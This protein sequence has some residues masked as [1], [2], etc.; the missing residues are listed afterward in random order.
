MD[1]DSDKG[2][3]P[4]REEYTGIRLG[5]Q[6][7]LNSSQDA[8]LL[9]STS[10]MKTTDDDD[11]GLVTILPD[12]GTATVIRKKRHNQKKLAYMASGHKLSAKFRRLSSSKSL[13]FQKQIRSR[14]CSG[15][16]SG[17]AEQF[18]APVEPSPGLNLGD[19]PIIDSTPM[20]STE[21]PSVK[22][23][24]L[25]NRSTTSRELDIAMAGL[26]EDVV[27]V[28]GRAPVAQKLDVS[29]EAQHVPGQHAIAQA[30]PAKLEALEMNRVDLA[31]SP[32]LVSTLAPL[33]P[34]A[35][36]FAVAF[37]KQPL[38]R[39]NR[40]LSPTTTSNGHAKSQRASAL[41]EIQTNKDAVLKA[42]DRQL[43]QRQQL[44]KLNSGDQQI[45]NDVRGHQTKLPKLTTSQNLREPH[46]KNLHQLQA[47][48][49]Y[50]SGMQRDLYY[51]S[52]VPVLSDSKKEPAIAFNDTNQKTAQ[53]VGSYAQQLARKQNPVVSN[54]RGTLAAVDASLKRNP[55]ENVA[56]MTEASVKV[57]YYYQKRL[58]TQ[59]KANNELNLQIKQLKGEIRGLEAALNTQKR[60]YSYVQETL[61]ELY[62]L[63]EHS[64]KLESENTKLTALNRKL[65]A[66][67][68]AV[69]QTAET[70]AGSETSAGKNNPINAI[71]GSQG[72]LNDSH[73][74]KK[75]ETHGVT[76]RIA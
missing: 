64:K 35:K 23:Q 45:A 44:A 10:D 11:G 69:S 43:K 20:D 6:N 76:T 34:L 66:K 60:E 37:T 74:G 38:T 17:S 19:K 26:E 15:T 48:E 39:Q 47:Q 58:E 32:K 56:A 71:F 63:R 49:K 46:A 73:T 28:F 25:A 68:S 31:Q 18:V 59:L 3:E 33:K 8:F 7:L 22:A 4:A 51:K 14:N 27:A 16:G 13:R 42:A 29:K 62:D 67:L 61:S 54:P 2:L 70:G 5:L 36:K 55:L 21:A 1:Q 57:K 65:E 50:N 24:D 12:D 41:P 52:S 9:D 53:D 30:L 72:K 75:T 40:P